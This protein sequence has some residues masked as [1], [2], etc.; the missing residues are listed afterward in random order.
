[1]TEAEGNFR[2]PSR[3]RLVYRSSILAVDEAE[4]LASTIIQAIGAFL[5]NPDIKI[6]ELDLFSQKNRDDMLQWNDNVWMTPVQPNAIVELIGRQALVRPNELAICAWDGELSYHELDRL[7]SDLAHYLQDAGVGRDVMVP[8]TFEKSMLAIIA[9]LGVLKAGGAFVPL[10]PALPPDRIKYMVDQVQGTVAIV[11]EKF[12]E[13]LAGHVERLITLTK[14]MLLGLPHWPAKV[15]YPISADSPA[16]V[17]FTSGSTGR[18]KG[19][20]ME[21]GA[22]AS[23]VHQASAVNMHHKSR[24]L[25]FASYSFAACTGEIYCALFVGATLCIPSDEDRF[26]RLAATMEDMRISWACLTPSAASS[27]PSTRPLRHLKT[28]IL[29]GEVMNQH[30]FRALQTESLQLHQALGC[31]EHSPVLCVSG[32]M[33][34]VAD[35]GIVG[36]SPTANVWVV[37]PDNHHRPV[38]VG[39]VGELM[40]ESPA[41]ARYYLEDH[42]RSSSVF[43]DTPRWLRDMNRGIGSR[44]YKSGDLVKYLADGSLR[45]VAR[46]DTQVKIRGQRVELGEIEFQIRQACDRLGRVIVEAAVPAKSNG[47]QIIVA[48]LCS[49]DF[50]DSEKQ[51][52]SPI[53]RAFPSLAG[54][55]APFYSI[56]Q[57]IEDFLPKVLPGYM[58]PSVYMPLRH[59]PSTL[60]GKVDR[61]TL[62]QGIRSITRVDLEDY[63]TPRAA[64][65]GPRNKLEERILMLYAETLELDSSRI[66]IHDS[67]IRLGG[68]SVIAMRLANRCERENLPLTASMILQRKTVAQI[69][70]SLSALQEGQALSNGDDEVSS[71]SSAW[72]FA[73]DPGSGSDSASDVFPCSA[74]QQGMLLSQLRNQELYRLRIVWEIE[75]RDPVSQIDIERLEEAWHQLCHRHPMLRTQIRTDMAGKDTAYQMVLKHHNDNSFV[76][77]HEEIDLVSMFAPRQ[78]VQ[79]KYTDCPQMTL[80]TGSAPRIYAML[81]INHLVMDGL[82]MSIIKRDLSVLYSHGKEGHRQMGP[83]CSYHNYVTHLSTLKHDAGI[84]FWKTR[85][86]SASSCILPSLYDSQVSRPSEGLRSVSIELDQL[87]A[88]QQFFRSH[89]VTLAT[90]LKMAWGILLRCYSG[91]DH[92]YFGDSVSGRDAPLS[93]IDHAVGPYIHEMICHIEFAGD[94][95]IWDT[96]Q[97]IQT[98]FLSALPY[99]H[100]SIA[101]IQHAIGNGSSRLFNTGI[102]FLP[103]LA[104]DRKHSNALNIVEISRL[105]PT[106][107]SIWAIPG[108]VNQTGLTVVKY[109]VVLEVQIQPDSAK[110]TIKYWSSFLDDKQARRLANTLREI[111]SQIVKGASQGIHPDLK[112]ANTSHQNF[113]IRNLQITSREDLDEIWRWNGNE[114]PMVSQCV[115]D[116]I[117]AFSDRQPAADAVCAWDGSFTYRDLNNIST[118]LAHHLQNIGVERGM[119]VPLLFE[120]SCWMPVA[121]LGVMK[122]GAA[123]VALDITQ[124]LERIRAITQLVDASVIIT[125]PAQ[126]DRASKTGVEK[127]FSLDSTV[128]NRLPLCLDR[129]LPAVQ[130]TDLLY[131]VFTSGSTGKPKGAKIS[132]QNF[133]SAVRYHQPAMGITAESRVLDFVTYA[134]DIAWSNILHALTAGAC[135][136]IPSEDDRQ[137]NIAK[138]MSATRVN[139]AFVTPTV[140]RLLNPKDTP[141]LR[142]LLCGGEFL[143]AA[144]VDQWAPHVRLLNT[145]G[146]AECTVISN[147]NPVGPRRRGNPGLGR[148]LGC[149]LWI[150]DPDCQHHLMPV[151]CTGE[152]WIEGPIVGEGYFGD[153]EK[154]AAAFFHQANWQRCNQRTERRWRLYRT[155]DLV[156]YDS[157][158]NIVFVGRRDAQVKVRGQRVDLAEVEYHIQRHLRGR[159]Q[160]NVVAELI[161]PSGSERPI[162]VAFLELGEAGHNPMNG[163]AVL[164]TTTSGLL[165]QLRRELPTSMI[166]AAFLPQEKFP[167]TANGKTDR[168]RLRQLGSTYSLEQLADLDPTRGDY[169]EPS[170]D[171]ERKLQSL[172]AAVLKISSQ[173]IS[174]NDSFLGIGGD[175]VGIMQLVGA[176]RE[177]GLAFTVADVFHHPRLEDLARLIKPVEAP[178]EG[179]P[180][181]ALLGPE[182][183]PMEC[184]A[185]AARQCAVTVAQIEDLYPC[186]PLQEGLLS[187]TSRTGDYID[188]SILELHDVV[189]LVR[190]QNVW[191][192]VVQSTP[193]LRTRIVSLPQQ[194]LTQA[195]LT[196][197]PTVHRAHDL[198]TYIHHDS[199]L[200]MGLGTPLARLAIVDPVDDGSSTPQRY[201]VVTMH[202]AVYDAWSIPL[203][204]DQ[205][206]KLYHQETLS[207]PV[208]FKH[209]IKH[210]MQTGQDASAYWLSQLTGFSSGPFPALPQST[211]RP[212][213]DQT[214]QYDISN[215]CWPRGDITSSTIIR[216]AWT[217]LT[218]WYTNT[219]DVIFGATVTGRQAPVPGIEKIVGPTIATV[220]VR[221]AFDWDMTVQQFLGQVQQQAVMMSEHEQIGLHGIRKIDPELERNSEFQSLLI[222]QPAAQADADPRYHHVFQG[223]RGRRDPRSTI[224]FDSFASYA[225]NLLCQVQSDGVELL[226]GYDARV[227][228]EVQVQRLAQQF[229]HI[230]RQLSVRDMDNK[231]LHTLSATS[232]E[233]LHD[234]WTWN[235]QVPD[236]VNRCVHETISESARREPDAV[237]VCAWDGSLTYQ[238]LENLS[239]Q[240]ANHLRRVGVGR[241]MVVPLYIQKSMWMP[242]AMLGVMKT[243]AASLTLD[244]SLPEERLRYMIDQAQ[245]TVIIAS[246]AQR[247]MADSLADEGSCTVICIDRDMM[248]HLPTPCMSCL[249]IVD[250]SSPLYIVFTSGSTGRPKGVVITHRNISSAIKAQEGRLR[251]GSRVFDFASYAFDISWFNFLQTVVSGQC[252]CIPSEMERKN[253]VSGSMIKLQANFAC[254]TPSTARMIDPAKV[255]ELKTLILAGEVPTTGDYL[256]WAPAVE[257]QNAYGPAECT[258][259]ATTTVRRNTTSKPGNIG[260]GMGVNTWIVDQSNDARLAPVGAIGELWLEGPLVG[261]GYHSD[262]ERTA[263]AFVDNP[264]WLD[265]GGPSHP[266]RKGRLYR[267]GDL[268]YYD[269]D[270]TLVFVGRKDAQVKIH[271]QRVELSEV[272]Y[273]V[274]QTI[275]PRFPGPKVVEVV[276]P[277]GRTNPI[278]VVFISMESEGEE[279]F[280][281]LAQHTEGWVDDLTAHLPMYMVPRI[282]LPIH[283]IPMTATGKVDRR[284]LRDI[285]SSYN[286]D[287]LTG[288]NPRREY[289]EPITGAERALQRLW[290]SVL[291]INPQTISARDSFLQI[292]GDS[293]TAM[294]LVGNAREQEGLAFTV[295]DVFRNPRLEDL[296]RHSFIADQLVAVT[297]PFSMLESDDMDARAQA[298]TKCGVSV[299]QI[300]DIYPCTP[301]QEGMISVTS[302]RPGDFIHRSILE[303]RDNI[304]IPGFKAAW[305]AVIQQ[306]PILRTRIVD[307]SEQGLLQ[308]VIAEDVAWSSSEDLAS[309]VHEDENLIMGLNTP[310]A[311]FAMVEGGD[312]RHLVLTLHHAIYDGWSISMVLSAVQDAYHMRE[313]PKLRPF[314]DFIKY[315]AQQRNETSQ[316]FWRKQFHGIQAEPFP[317]LPSPRY[318][319]RVDR[320]STHSISGL[321]WP[322]GGITASTVLRAAWAVLTAR[323]R[324][325]PDPGSQE[326]L[327]GVT[328]TGRQ[329]QF[330][331]IE[332]VVG[333]TIATVPLRIRLSW[334]TRCQAFL[335]QVQHQA[336]EMIEFEQTGLQNIRRISPDA[337]QAT[338]FQ[339]LLV[340]QPTLFEG[341]GGNSDV[342]EPVSDEIVRNYVEMLKSF[343]PYAV[344]LLCQLKSDG[345]EFA[346]CFDS[347]VIEPE[348][349]ERLLRQLEYT[350]R[351][352]CSREPGHLDR[353]L[354]AIDPVCPVDRQDIWSWNSHLTLRSAQDTPVHQRISNRASAFPHARAICAWDG[355]MD[356]AELD[357][358]STKVAH[359]VTRHESAVGRGDIVLL[360]C[361][362]SFWVPVCMLA[363]MKIGAVALLLSS[364]VTQARMDAICAAVSPQLILTNIDG[365]LSTINTKTYAMSQ[366]IADSLK[367]VPSPLPPANTSPDSLTHILFTSGS[368]GVP[369]GIQWSQRALAANVDAMAQFDMS[370]DSRVF[371]FVSY[372]FDVSIIETYAALQIGACLC[373][374]SETE[375][376]NR[377]GPS[378][379]KME[380]TW[381]CITPCTS[382]IIDPSTC[383]SLRTCV[384]AGEALQV[385][386]VERWWKYVTVFNWYGPAECST[387][388]SCRATRGANMWRNGTIGSPLSC[389]C[390][391]VDPLNAEILLPVGAVGELLLEGPPMMSGYVG[392]ESHTDYFVTPQWLGQGP[393]RSNGFNREKR[394]RILYKTGDLVRYQANGSLI[395]LGRNDSQAKIRGQRVELMEIETHVQRNLSHHGNI[396]AVAEIIT[397]STGDPIL[398]V[399]LAISDSSDDE[400]SVLR[401]V[402][403][404]LNKRLAGH[405]PQYMIPHIYIPV[406]HIPLT[407]SGKTDRAELR[408][409][410]ASLTLEQLSALRPKTED[411]Q[412]PKTETERV[413]QQLWSNVL[414]IALPSVSAHF[415]EIGGDSIAAMRLVGAMREHGLSITV[416]DIFKTPHLMD[417]AKRARLA[418]SSGIDIAPFS[419]LPLPSAADTA[420]SHAA[421]QCGIPIEQIENLYPCTT[422]QEGMLSLTTRQD[423]EY[424]NQS[425]IELNSH[426]D[427][428]RFQ[429]AWEEVIQSTP[430]FRTRIVDI[431]DQGLTQVVLSDDP[432]AKL[433]TSRDISL[434]LTECQNIKMGLATPLARFGLVENDS[435]GRAYLVLTLHHALYD[436]WSFPL[437][438]EEVRRTYYKRNAR[439]SLVPFD[440]FIEYLSRTNGG[441][442]F[443]SFWASQFAGI[444]AEPFPSP[445]SP[446]H[447]PKADQTLYLDVTGLTWRTDGFTPST[448][449]RTAWA[450][451]TARYQQSTDVLFGATVTGRQ[452]PMEGI[453]RIIGPT[454]ATVPVRVKFSWEM[455]LQSLLKQVQDQAISMVEYEQTGLQVIQRISSEAERGTEFQSLLVVQPP[456]YEH[457]TSGDDEGLFVPRTELERLESMRALKDFTSYSVMLLCQLKANG[458]E[459]LIS[460]DSNVIEQAQVQRI[461]QQMQHILHQLCAGDRQDTVASIDVTSPQDIRDIRA[462]NSIIP[463]IRQARVEELI[464]ERAFQCPENIAIDA[465]DGKMTYSQMDL[466]SSKLAQYLS[467]LGVSAGDAVALHFTKSMWMPVSMVA[468]MKLGAVILPLSSSQTRARINTIIGLISP[469]LMLTNMDGAS[470]EAVKTY[471]ITRL[472]SEASL[473]SDKPILCARPVGLDDPAHIQFTSGSTGIPKGIVWHHRSLTANIQ[474]MLQRLNLNSK[475]RVFQFVSYDFDISN[476]ETYAAFA[477]GACLC[478]PN[479]DDRTNRL[480][481]SISSFQSSW[482]FLTPSASE[483]VVPDEIPTLHTLVLGGE[484]LTTT[485][486]NKWINHAV[487]LNW[488]GPGECAAAALCTVNPDTWKPG[489]I[490]PP[491]ASACWVVDPLDVDI[492]LPVGATGELLIDGPTMMSG[493]FKGTVGTQGHFVTPKWFH[494][495][496]YRYPGQGSRLYRTGDMVRYLNDGTLV[497]VG[498]MD[499]QVKIRG[500]RVELT[501]VEAHIRSL[502]VESGTQEPVVA[503]IV[504]PDG[505]TD[506]ILAAFISIGDVIDRPLE[507]IRLALTH[508]T[509]G[510]KEKLAE[511]LPRHMLPSAYIPVKVIPLTPN[512]KVNRPKLRAIGASYTLEQ[513]G[514]FSPTRSQRRDP[515]SAMEIRIQ[516]LWASILKIEPQSIS[517]NDSFLQIGG[518][519]IAAMRLVGAARKCGILITVADIF[520]RPRLEDLAQCAQTVVSSVED[521]DIAPFSLLNKGIEPDAARELAARQC[522][523][524]TADV[525]DI[526][527]C[528]PLQEGL[529][530]ITNMRAGDYVS[531]EIRKLHPSIDIERVRQTLNEMIRLLPILRTRIVDLANVGLVQVV[532]SSKCFQVTSSSM[533]SSFYEEQ[534]LD[535]MGLGT[536]LCRFVFVSQDD[537]QVYLGWVIHHALYDGWSMPLMLGLL[538]DLYKGAAVIPPPP[539]SQ[540]IKYQAS[541]SSGAHKYWEAQL[542]GSVAPQFPTLPSPTYKPRADEIIQYSFRDISFANSDITPP[543]LIRASWALLTAQYCGSSDV[544]FGSTMTGR[545]VPVSGIERMMGPTITTVPIRVNLSWDTSVSDYLSQV[546]KQMVDMIPFE[547]TGL[548]NIRKISPEIDQASQFQ[549]LLVVQADSNDIH[550]VADD[551]LFDY[552]P[553]AESKRSVSQLNSF[554]TYAMMWLCQLVGSRIEISVSFDSN[555]LPSAQVQRLAQQLEHIIR[556]LGSDP[557]AQCSLRS[558]TLVNEQDISTIWTWNATVPLPE[559][560]SLPSLI[561]ESASHHPESCALE[562]W[563]GQ[564]TYSTLDRVSS[565][566]ASHLVALGARPS[567]TIALCFEKSIWM[568]V[569]ILAVL[570]TGAAFVQLSA[571]TSTSRIKSLF[572]TVKVLFALAS[573][574]QRSHLPQ[575]TE[576]YTVSQLLESSYPSVK[577]HPAILSPDATASVLFTSGSTGV[578]K[579]IVWS[580]RTLSTNVSDVGRAYA[581]QPNSRVLQFAA[582]DFDVSILETLATLVHGGCLCIPSEEERQGRLL[583]TMQERSINLAFLT[584]SVSRV[585]SPV[586]L[587]N[588]KTL[589]LCGEPLSAHDVAKWADNVSLKNWYGPAE[590]SSTTSCT[591]ETSTW[592]QGTI[593]VPSA[594]VCWVVDPHNSETIVP[595]GAVGE[596]LVEGPILAASIL[597]KAGEDGF[598]SPKWLRDGHRQWTGR[599]G[600]LYK[601]GDLVRYNA[602]G[603]LLFIGRKDAQVKIRGQRVEL[604]EVEHHVRTNLADAVDVPVAAEVVSLRGSTQAILVAF[605][606]IGEGL[607]EAEL[608]STLRRYTL[609]LRDRLS[610]KL[611]PYMVPNAFI[612]IESLPMTATDKVHRRKLREIGASISP[613]QLADHSTSQDDYRPPETD[614]ERIIQQLWATLLNLDPDIIGRDSNFLI[615]GGDSIKAM[616]LVRAIHDQNLKLA[617]SDCFLHPCLWDLAMTADEKTREIG[618]TKIAGRSDDTKERLLASGALQLVGLSDAHL[619]DAFPVTDFQKFYVFALQEQ[620]LEKWAYCYTDLPASLDVSHVVAICHRLWNHL[621]ILRVI[622]LIPEGIPVQALF[623]HL[624]PVVEV[625]QVHGDLDT[626]SKDLYNADFKL[627]YEPGRPVTRFIITYTQEGRIRMALRLSHAQFDGLSLACIVSTFASF[628]SGQEPPPNPSFS[629]YIAHLEETRGKAFSHWRA[630]LYGSRPSRFLS[631]PPIPNGLSSSPPDDSREAIILRRHLPAPPTHKEYTPATI[632]TSLCARAIAR[633]THSSDVVFGYLT[634]GRP[635]LLPELQSMAGPCLNIVPVRVPLTEDGQ[636]ADV[637]SVVQKQRLRGYEIDSD[638]LSDII[639]NCT[640]WPTDTQFDFGVHFLNIEDQLTT[641]ISG[642]AIQM[643]PYSTVPA[644][645]FPTIILAAKPIEHG[646]WEVEARGGSD[647]YSKTDLLRVLE[648]LSHQIAS[649]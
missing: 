590:C 107:V 57:T 101:D 64:R 419:L 366:I 634:T 507:D 180:C 632:F 355:D 287:R 352:L 112:S 302:R 581:I 31:T 378:L 385:S 163:L 313:T 533:S 608:W 456:T 446:K 432:A 243:G 479:E 563:D 353:T 76:V 185:T 179:I 334:Q 299:A 515:C 74:I 297:L 413:L 519:S 170:T 234:I 548:Q 332:K 331:G 390:W 618:D 193:I 258:P 132:H 136:C 85:L 153:S 443:E 329:G 286:I 535:P 301:L 564:M 374:P 347:D 65:V 73:D 497:Y 386:T 426:V 620:S 16:Y 229:H 361:E 349:V 284:R 283:Q 173:S 458:V 41:L 303:L 204:L 293:V 544:I 571:A 532:L 294:Q 628:C 478:I 597:N 425:M 637:L 69:A 343:S 50:G 17:L 472:I 83:V 72:T 133:S 465:W 537:G 406:K 145:Y 582:Y 448:I 499:A 594:C 454:I 502:M 307:M 104:T 191:E 137:S 630:L 529:L 612:P 44:V 285:G 257:L 235:A 389:A 213:A 161:L 405:I 388:V 4:N 447:K 183:D 382:S 269:I 97:R 90:V 247:E 558:L 279:A 430:I 267:T 376:L 596:L 510:L 511:Q 424:I 414:E 226:I 427:I 487:V 196:T 602:D 466:T 435:N 593:G 492:L 47:S 177:Q 486:V 175:S 357:L 635:C 559:E 14:E 512:G 633:L 409:H 134:F 230:I 539:F 360:H 127:V 37:D 639:E 525:E 22:L 143:T 215:I 521:E 195:V 81:D 509:R 144:D 400:S 158:G 566:L 244:A 646:Q 46:K 151:G 176:A 610:I 607:P 43:I 359:C 489:M 551:C 162:L 166:P 615:L 3:L 164:R 337:E 356:Y 450:L 418:K 420:R 98:E 322:S 648:E 52:A 28:L 592:L 415:L 253:D 616:Q 324:P 601:T 212:Q 256:R 328:V 629:T 372:D 1:M 6:E 228:G 217:L 139:Y 550:H 545:Q 367:I 242:V 68:D 496:A 490:G 428:V 586:S 122:A 369:K 111:L 2:L 333:P 67:F 280:A 150:V 517:A 75:E 477:V 197:G 149:N 142:V 471:N 623:R 423:N 5:A 614:T 457:Q 120:K 506:P 408:K 621:D 11:S 114:Q 55:S 565:Q 36:R 375:R 346:A 514:E 82:S 513:L 503:E 245:A 53:S 275:S 148:G 227:L 591:I 481:H 156:R 38:P 396:P 35:C 18:P 318:E 546:Q 10:D 626:A 516:N 598:I 88:Y 379:A 338:Q 278:L 91:C 439:Q 108:R 259:L 264:P 624:V 600:R 9:Q 348:Q 381:T 273:Y 641:E 505:N 585:L 371:Q 271:G 157:D 131:L 87:L 501:D 325:S 449:I 351:Q 24:V 261:Q 354:A 445:L 21:H 342:F 345:V 66:G 370:S 485:V 300:E 335:E 167:I 214:L 584:P 575:L 201:L 442:G 63:Q 146:P 631:A 402:T 304:D 277:D 100:I 51:D 526:Y 330:Q 48:F 184:Q 126:C 384:F 649:V 208:P 336:V 567:V 468:L 93:G 363:L 89:D 373:I 33:K 326:V 116:L 412:E 387:A 429:T 410:G 552:N 455:D 321:Q 441:P 92:V 561:S 573:P 32:P 123:S 110:G 236:G 557:C 135:L 54:R 579:G 500:Q 491:F 495:N 421:E 568:P 265:R 504:V 530:A 282:F 527:P 431:P 350:I 636:F 547:Q 70:L 141:T 152:L 105:D 172:W 29:V 56:L 20:V 308:V 200:S 154:T 358:I 312:R 613:E 19:C 250:P 34:S 451:L 310:L 640:D 194:G 190:F 453:E 380:A 609:G 7:S 113:S 604:A 78:I 461:S 391:I 198:E 207:V 541:N 470:S 274:Q 77:R 221:V 189:D 171:T 488:Y 536:P 233:D 106:E 605:L 42:A 638:Q 84:Q 298:A 555:I 398:V 115:H 266:G 556:I 222:I 218:A 416:A 109:D 317:S 147:A 168:Q 467:D 45:Y 483:L 538:S 121:V 606:A 58:I 27:L 320:T 276:L 595:I 71:Q 542:A 249:P 315:S 140:A 645:T 603:T 155:G 255:P 394:E 13:R 94:E 268:A 474:V 225:V 232:A 399:F 260:V 437:L 577:F 323:Y 393:K 528:T 463:A 622:F 560:R 498:R 543:T 522:D 25:Q 129:A 288:L 238:E 39:V 562:A 407:A 254:L 159:L 210:I 383:P 296:A 174:A 403:H 625:H 368:T 118:R 436:G 422:L 206:I 79:A 281:T 647:F 160:T 263:A 553:E 569:A 580:H 291:N 599:C 644:I 438:L 295:A 523:V 224:G 365:A 40:I 627:P 231:A 642:E 404:R 49:S 314:C 309:Y 576:T 531:C 619:V 119:I 578:P 165:D 340:I 290:A 417:L 452:A 241:G 188:Q 124:P 138:F 219:P 549:S 246:V 341:H 395:Y 182:I 411:Y 62:R 493:Y 270:G 251:P 248:D 401:H 339:T 262:L 508:L 462:W 476:L 30:H 554:T 583:E 26:S 520:Q 460:F 397:P 8:I 484:F 192:T 434:Y 205:V 316:A 272:E 187:I 305:T 377:L 80:F 617:V 220:P 464:V 518:N 306:C 433:F 587:P 237:A 540:F 178:V 23:V 311:R 95:S 572:A 482:V 12:T 117:S 99:K 181:F 319:P 96:L 611:P 15:L 469:R 362:K 480:G 589:V 344:M 524:P 128:A 216:A 444:E 186:T 574:H 252:L 588:L 102:T 223:D 459:L 203:L 240:L 103:Q 494:Q 125:S 392:Q 209:F 473:L 169:R 61:H 199:Q 211:Y 289:R 534:R 570:K 292:G 202:H 440:H 364:S 643:V 60:T 327:F 475:S 86:S 130:P 59:I 239:T